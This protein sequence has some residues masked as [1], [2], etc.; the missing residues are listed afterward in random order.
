MKAKKGFTFVEVVLFLAIT[1]AIFAMIAGGVSTA[2]ARRRYNE[3]TNDI[4]EQLR[5]AYSAVINVENVRERTNESSFY[6][7]LPAA[8]SGQYG[9]L[10][11]NSSDTDNYPGRT[12]CAIYG[13][14]I[15][16]GEK[17]QGDK[18]FRYD[19]IGLAKINERNDWNPSEEDSVIDNLERV[20]ADI[21][22]I[23]Q[24][25]GSNTRCVGALAGTS[26]Y[27]QPEKGAIIEN[28]DS[29]NRLKGAIVIVR[30]PVSGTIH[31]YFYASSGNVNSRYNETFDVQAWLNE[32]SGSRECSQYR[33]INSM[34]YYSNI[35]FLTSAMKNGKLVYKSNVDP[36][37]NANLD[38]CVGSD[39]LDAVGNQR[40]AIRI[41][42]DGSTESSVELLSERDSASVCLK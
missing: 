9:G 23:K 22:T 24:D 15:T 5:N 34:S 32:F 30:S 39:D 42:G 1:S 36:D 35:G 2:V 41:H 33:Y 21:V 20:N 25:N 37:T 38:L 13:Q 8:F 14:V 11:S 40:R 27:F 17:Y 31:T 6:C 10:T 19:I 28:T 16:F 29:R 26:T 7:T 18:V 3:T 12:R 4:V